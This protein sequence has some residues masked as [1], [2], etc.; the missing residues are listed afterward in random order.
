MHATVEEA[1]GALCWVV[2]GSLGQRAPLLN[3]LP[4][5]GSFS[6]AELRLL[7]PPSLWLWIIVRP[8]R[9]FDQFQTTGSAP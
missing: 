2:G 1:H 5:K 9:S 6:S 3:S 8:E 4:E 7:P